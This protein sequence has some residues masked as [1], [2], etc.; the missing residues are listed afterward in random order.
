MEFPARLINGQRWLGAAFLAALLALAAIE[1]NSPLATAMRTG[2]PWSCW[3]SFQPAGS[4][5]GVAR[6]FLALY[7]PSRRTLE[8]IYFPETASIPKAKAL[9]AEAAG[10]LFQ[11]PDNFIS[12]RPSSWSEA[13]AAIA[14]KER[15][16]NLDARRLSTNIPLFDKLLG[17]LEIRRF[18]PGSLHPAWLPEPAY[19]REYFIGLFGPDAAAPGPG[20]LITAEILNSSERKGIA[21]QVTKILRSKGIDVV[22]YGNLPG[23]QSKTL[24]YDRTGRFSNAFFVQEKLPCPSSEA[25]TQINPK[26][27]VDVTVILADDCAGSN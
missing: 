10:E 11:P 22:N 21:S 26:R 9:L 16:L 25:I 8:L 3:A 6:L 27:L 2:K 23:R 19:R 7:R 18:E 12:A 4:S 1:Y 17:A 14:A 20:R 24:V 15:L 5:A 13:D